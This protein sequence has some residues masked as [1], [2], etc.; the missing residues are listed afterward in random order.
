MRI[1]FKGCAALLML[2]YPFLAWWGLTRWG[3][4]PVAAL[5]AVTALF[6][7]AAVRDAMSLWAALPAGALALWG[8]TAGS[9]YALTLYPVL[10][11]LLGL[12]LFSQSLRRGMP[13]CERFARLAHPEL[14][15]EGVRW[16]RGVTAAWCVFF[17]L[18]GTAAMITVLIGDRDLWAFYNGGLAYVLM[19]AMA[20]GEYILR[21]RQQ[22][23]TDAL[24]RTRAS[25]ADAPH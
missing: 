21:K 19:G 20:L 22:A 7:A 10:M 16:C 17:V 6:R 13:M 14:P 3:T 23:R 25:D 9:E 2:L 5:L 24:N 18:N 15:P 12:T 4:A 11:N 8:W 1:F